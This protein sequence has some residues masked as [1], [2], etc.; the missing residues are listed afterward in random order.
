MRELVI[1]IGAHKTGTTSLQSCFDERAHTLR[2]AGVLYPHSNWYHHSQHR[3]AF[4]MKGMRDPKGGAVPD[5]ADEIAALNA[6]I[7]AGGCDRIFISS[8]EFFSCPPDGITA[9][10]EGLDVD[11]VRIVATLRRPDTLLVS[12]YNQKVKQPGNRFARSIQTFVKDPVLL[13]PDM[14]FLGCITPWIDTFGEANTTVLFYENG[15]SISQM[16]GVLGLPEDILPQPQRLNESVPGVVIE[17][18]RIAK[19]NHMDPAEQTKLYQLALR[20]MADRPPF[21]LGD[22]DRRAII[23]ALLP[24][25][26]ALFKRLG[27]E[28]PYRLAHYEPQ[29]NDAQRANITYADMMQL[30]D[31]LLKKQSRW[32]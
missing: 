9:L 30:L 17:L 22:I 8:E 4:A 20:E 24:S 11:R 28:N 25:M 21:F 32:A 27:I 16:L 6:A 19:F 13:D 12:M 23:H 14:D 7:A 18:M 15:P 10:K 1:H 2:S 31:H 29:G 26:N 5:L 3:L